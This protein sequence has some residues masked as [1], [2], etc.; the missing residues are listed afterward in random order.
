M[1]QGEDRGE[2]PLDGRYRLERPLGGSNRSWQA[3]DELLNRPV[4][5]HFL[6]TS[7]AEA[8]RQSDAVR[9]LSR[10]TDDRLVEVLDLVPEAGFIATEWV[11]GRS[12]AELDERGLLTTDTAVELIAEAAEA[13]ATAHAAGLYHGRI[14]GGS[15]VWSDSGVV[16][17]LGLC[18]RTSAGVATTGQLAHHDTRALRRILD[19]ALASTRSSRRLQRVVRRPCNAAVELA[20]ALAP[21]RPDESPLRQQLVSAEPANAPLQLTARRTREVMDTHIVTVSEDTPANE[22]SAILARSHCAVVPVVDAAGHVTGLVS[23]SD[24]ARWEA[25]ATAADL[26]VS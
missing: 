15:I 23:A 11:T 18:L 9:R 6:P 5:I 12:L 8:R 19:A 10:L 4:A 24:L 21:F 13:L 7:R 17:L 14:E 26:Q 16:K 25:D 2:E 22:L 20:E 3:R 1:D